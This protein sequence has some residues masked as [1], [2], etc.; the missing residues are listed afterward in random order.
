MSALAAGFEVTA[1]DYYPEALEFVRAECGAE[2]LA[3]AGSAR[4][5]LAAYPADLVGFDFVVAADVLYERDYCRLIAAAMRQSLA[6]DGLGILTDPQRVKA[7]AFPE[8]C[9]RAG[10]AVSAP[11]VHGPLSVPGGDRGV[12]Q[13]V[14]LFEI[15]VAQ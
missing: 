5:G 13:T 4:G 14:N 9:R 2:W 1:V 12:C 10:L 15:R 6:P 8:E 3:G 11:E 7:E